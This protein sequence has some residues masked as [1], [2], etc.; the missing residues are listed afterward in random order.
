MSEPLVIL[1]A[2]E[3]D[4]RITG[5]VYK[6]LELN[7]HS[8]VY[9]LGEIAK[10]LKYQK[11]ESVTALIR[12]GKIKAVGEGKNTRITLASYEEYVNN[13]RLAQQRIIRK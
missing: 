12:S 7:R 13:D 3:L 11:V 6:A 9:T 2:S 10:K 4:E 8:E 1:T 5:A